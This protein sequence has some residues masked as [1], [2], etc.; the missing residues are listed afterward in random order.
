M[1]P[2]QSDRVAGTKL[3]ELRR[4]REIAPFHK[5]TASLFKKRCCLGDLN[6][7]KLVWSHDHYLG[8]LPNYVLLIIF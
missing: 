6:Q 8:Q 4:L 1:S 2:N 3:K 7:A 5:R